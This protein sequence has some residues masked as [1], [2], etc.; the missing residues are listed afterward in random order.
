VDAYKD[1]TFDPV[2]FPP[3]QV[4]Q[5]V[6]QLHN[7]HQHYVIIT[8]P[9]IAN[10]TSYPPYEQGSAEDLWIK[11]SKGNYFI[12]SVWPGTTVFPDFWNPKAFDFWY[13]QIAT[14]H[15]TALMDGLCKYIGLYWRLYWRFYRN[16]VL[17]NDHISF[18]ANLSFR[19]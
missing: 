5:F 10:Q 17:S 9:G 18:G 1:F 7:N 13:Q 6:Q 16:I 14:F 8:D 15:Q 12:G 3:A 11:D 19:D 2:R 4:T